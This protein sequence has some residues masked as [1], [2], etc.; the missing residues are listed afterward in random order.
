MERKIQVDSWASGLE[1]GKDGNGDIKAENIGARIAL[2][3]E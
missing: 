1:D 2:G 3:E